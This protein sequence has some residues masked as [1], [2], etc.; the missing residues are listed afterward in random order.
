MPLE[1][2]VNIFVSFD[3]VKLNTLSM[4]NRENSLVST[5]IIIPIIIKQS[6]VARI[7]Q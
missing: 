1:A 2:A 6:I 7:L 5:A 4:N 3:T